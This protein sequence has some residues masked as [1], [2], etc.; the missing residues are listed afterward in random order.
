LRARAKFTAR[1]VGRWKTRGRTRTRNCQSESSSHLLPRAAAGD[2]RSDAIP[3]TLLY[4]VHPIGAAANPS[5]RTFVNPSAS[6]A[7]NPTIDFARGV[8]A[9]PGLSGVHSTTTMPPL[10][11]STQLKRP[12]AATV[13]VC[14]IQKK[15]KTAQTS[16][17]SHIESSRH[18]L[19]STHH[20]RRLPK[21]HRR[22]IPPHPTV[23]PTWS[24]K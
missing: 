23:R 5:T 3:P 11:R 15:G 10:A 6:P 13:V 8:F 20:C 19:N 16:R 24:I 12:P 18:W 2:G 7:T 17:P 9:V 4:F 21:R 14:A 1:V 22:R